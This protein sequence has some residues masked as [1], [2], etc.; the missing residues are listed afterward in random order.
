M[1]LAACQR[2]PRQAVHAKW[3]RAIPAEHWKTALSVAHTPQTRSRY[4]PGDASEIPFELIYLAENQAVALYEVGAVYGP[5][6]R[7]IADPLRSK[8]L[9][10]DVDARLSSIVDLTNPRH[11]KSL[12]TSVQELTG[13]WRVSYPLADA[14]TQR[15]GSALFATE[16]VEGFLTISAKMPRCKTL[17]IFPQRLHEGSEL[18]FTDTITRKTHRI[19][20][21]DP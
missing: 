1:K 9:I 20:R 19:A 7:P 3:Y 16:N 21:P 2:F 6:D 17:V 4:N 15:L 10:I 18:V 5:T 13:D 11:H 14:P 12:G 8:M